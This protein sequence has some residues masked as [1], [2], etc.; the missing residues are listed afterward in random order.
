MG[1][2]ESGT[3]ADLRGVEG[4]SGR[5]SDGR[6]GPSS[7]SVCGRFSLRT[8]DRGRRWVAS[9]PGPSTPRAWVAPAL[10]PRSDACTT[11]YPTSVDPLSLLRPFRS[12]ALRGAQWRS[13]GAWEA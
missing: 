11:D 10:G 1:D 12:H 6:P 3:L 2:H 4:V 5:G 9:F 8:P 13:L 7:S